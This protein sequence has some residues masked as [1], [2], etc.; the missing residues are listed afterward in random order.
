MISDNSYPI[1]FN[2]WRLFWKL[3]SAL[4]ARS[5]AHERQKLSPRDDL[6]HR[7]KMATAKMRVTLGWS[8]YTGTVGTL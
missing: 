2:F 1:T 6:E 5:E 7:T 8:E 3:H 4:K